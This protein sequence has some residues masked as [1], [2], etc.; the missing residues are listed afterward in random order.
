VTPGQNVTA[1]HDLSGGGGHNQLSQG[2]ANVD[3]EHGTTEP[4]HEL[5][6]VSNLCHT[7]VYYVNFLVAHCK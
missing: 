4:S 6:N 7:R 3:S 5:D 2:L 1:Q